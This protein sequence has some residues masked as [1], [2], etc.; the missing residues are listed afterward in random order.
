M[1]QEDDNTDKD[2]SHIS[3]HCTHRALHDTSVRV[4]TVPT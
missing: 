1:M 4:A 2:N 3:E